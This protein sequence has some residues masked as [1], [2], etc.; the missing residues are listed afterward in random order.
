[1]SFAGVTIQPLA[2]GGVLIACRGARADDL[3]ARIANAAVSAMTRDGRRCSCVSPADLDDIRK[4]LRDAAARMDAAAAA[5]AASAEPDARTVI[6]VQFQPGGGFVALPAD[7]FVV[8]KCADG[9]LELRPTPAALHDATV[10]VA[11]P[12][13]GDRVRVLPN[14]VI[15]CEPTPPGCTGRQSAER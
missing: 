2:D 5:Q 12:S 9:A 15:R 13:D 4:I 3:V 7:R 8:V 10:L 11:H 6:Q 1:M 14:G